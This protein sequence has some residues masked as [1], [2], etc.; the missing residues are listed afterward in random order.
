M[1]ATTSGGA[2][3]RATPSTTNLHNLQQPPMLQKSFLQALRND[4]QEQILL[5]TDIPPEKFKGLPCVAFSS[6]EIQALAQR[7]ESPILPIWISIKDL[8][9]HLHSKSSLMRIGNLFGKA[10][11]IDATTENFGRPSTARVCVEVDISKPPITKFYVK[12]GLNPLL[13]TATFEEL[14]EYCGECK[15]VGRHNSQCKFFKPQTEN[16]KTQANQTTDGRKIPLET[17][18]QQ[19]YKPISNQSGKQTLQAKKPSL[20]KYNSGGT[21]NPLPNNHPTPPLNPTASNNNTSILIHDSKTSASIPSTSKPIST[22]PNNSLSPQPK[23]SLTETPSPITLTPNNSQPTSK[24]STPP[25][26]IPTPSPITLNNQPTSNNNQPTSGPNTPT[27]MPLLKP[28]PSTTQSHPENFLEEADWEILVHND[29]LAKCLVSWEEN[30]QLK[31]TANQPLTPPHT[32]FDDLHLHTENLSLTPIYL[33]DTE[34]PQ[35]HEPL[36]NLPSAEL[37]LPPST[38]DSSASKQQETPENK[39]YQVRTEEDIHEQPFTTVVRKSKR[40]QE[41]F[42]SH[43]QPQHFSQ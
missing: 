43:N 42:S 2:A 13:L 5:P 28:Q 30:Q 39:D 35:K 21:Q 22:Q 41:K 36:K 38:T 12:N 33:S 40:L 9:I 15:G 4:C 14:P 17:S 1:P 19:K 26:E 3:G 16:L 18:M 6:E 8:P 34:P 23:T 27:P 7:Y 11:K 10:L 29:I 37:H 32:S 20:P 24:Q 25:T 31:P